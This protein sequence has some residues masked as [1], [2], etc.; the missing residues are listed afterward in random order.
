MFYIKNNIADGVVIET[1]F[2]G[3]VMTRCPDCGK[4][5]EFDVHDFTRDTDCDFDFCG[6]RVYCEECSNKKR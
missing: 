4:E 3:E 1:E 5:M 2:T 6:T